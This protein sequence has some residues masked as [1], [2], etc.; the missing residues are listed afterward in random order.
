MTLPVGLTLL[1]NSESNGAGW[2]ILMAGAVLVIVPILIVFAALQRYIVAGLTQGSVTGYPGPPSHPCSRTAVIQPSLSSITE[3]TRKEPPWPTTLTGRYFLGLAGVSAGA[4]ALAACG[5]PSHRRLAPPATLPTSTS[6]ASSRR[7]SIDFWSNHPGKSQ[8]VEKA[9]IE[10]STPST[11]TS[12][13][14]W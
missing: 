3:A 4:A 14:T 11:L 9:I 12:R 2:G 1:Q 10:S 8:D 13:S 5:G 6:A 7:R